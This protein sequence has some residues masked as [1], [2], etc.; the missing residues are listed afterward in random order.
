MN[1]DEFEQFVLKFGKDILRFCRMTARDSEN[2]DE[3]YQE[4]VHTAAPG[5][6]RELA[7]DKREQLLSQDP[8]LTDA[9]LFDLIEPCQTI[10]YNQDEKILAVAAFA[11]FRTGHPVKGTVFALFGLASLGLLLCYRSRLVKV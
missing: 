8:D 1:H 10:C 3:L 5:E 9:E 2:G 11:L 7:D 6:Q 4:I